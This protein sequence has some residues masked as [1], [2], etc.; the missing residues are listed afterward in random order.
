MNLFGM[1]KHRISF[2]PGVRQ[3]ESG[4]GAELP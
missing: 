2:L 4:G 1:K 3:R